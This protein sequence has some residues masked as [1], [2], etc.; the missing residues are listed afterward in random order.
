MKNLVILLVLLLACSAMPTTPTID[1]IEI[2][3]WVVPWN[4]TRP[5]DPYAVSDKRVWF[6]GQV[7]DYVAYLEP[8]TGVSGHCQNRK[9]EEPFRTG[10]GRKKARASIAPQEATLSGLASAGM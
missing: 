4:N 10:S 1:P 2:T 8:E 7:A 5:R 9:A 6:V 3:E